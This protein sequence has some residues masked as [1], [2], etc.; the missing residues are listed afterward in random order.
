[1]AIFYTKC[2]LDSRVIRNANVVL[3]DSHQAK[4]RE[5]G[6]DN[7][8]LSPLYCGSEATGWCE[9]KEYIRKY[10]PGLSLATAMAISGAAANPNTGFGGDGIAR[11]R[12]MSFLLSLLGIRSGYWA[13]NPNPTKRAKSGFPNMLMPG[14]SQGLLPGT[15]HE[16]AMFVD[17]TDG[18]HF[19]NLGLYELVRRE[20][21]HIIVCDASYDPQNR[22]ECL[23]GTLSRIE[24]D[25]NVKVRF[26]DSIENLWT[27]N[28]RGNSDEILKIGD[29]VSKHGFAFAKISYNQNRE[30]VLVYLKPSLAGK[31]LDELHAY[32]LHN[33]HFP[34][35]RT[36]DQFFDEYQFEAYRKLG[37]ELARGALSA[38]R[39][40]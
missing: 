19:D 30:G 38:W 26:L 24:L 25:F 1:M 14:V 16:D 6:G 13:P 37:F 39:K 20:L 23:F 7:F 28:S 17:L 21:K 18:G 40:I 35:D 36:S 10:D 15:L 29:C 3:V 11:S 32:K 12:M 8:I 27:F 9:S 34:H 4:Y 2:S 22:F 33:P 5:R 31:L